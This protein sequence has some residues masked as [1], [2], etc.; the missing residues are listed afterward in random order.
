M[1]DGH[2]VYGVLSDREQRLRECGVLLYVTPTVKTTV[3]DRS[4]L[5]ENGFAVTE[6]NIPS[7]STDTDYSER[8]VVPLCSSGEFWVEFTMNSSKGVCKLFR[9]DRG[10]GGG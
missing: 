8:L 4:F 7:R 3:G 10:G 1:P 5:T 2:R 6:T 9:D